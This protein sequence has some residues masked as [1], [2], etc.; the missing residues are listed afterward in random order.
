MER[1]FGTWKKRFPCLHRGLQTNMN[2]SV[3][4]ICATAVLHNIGLTR[5]NAN[6]FE[7]NIQDDLL[8]VRNINDAE[9]GLDFRRHFI[10]QHFAQ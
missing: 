9:R 10:H 4:I 7:D 6:D 5:D 2:T 3:A 8:P 1:L